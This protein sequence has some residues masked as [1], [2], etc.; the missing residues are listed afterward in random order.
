VSSYTCRCYILN[1]L[2]K[3]TNYFCHHYLNFYKS[4]S[5]SRRLLDNY[6]HLYR[7]CSIYQSTNLKANHNAARFSC[8][9]LWSMNYE[10]PPINEESRPIGGLLLYDELL[11][12]LTGLPNSR[13]RRRCWCFRWPEQQPGCIC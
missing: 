5:K 2:F 12:V 4:E 8:H 7:C 10:P 1:F 3:S 6:W 9:A 11:Q 13:F